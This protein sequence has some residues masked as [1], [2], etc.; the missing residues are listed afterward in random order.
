MSDTSHDAHDHDADEHGEHGD[1][2]HEEHHSHLK[3][4]LIAAGI[5]TLITVVEVVSL[6][7][8]GLS[9][10]MKAFLIIG[11]AVGKFI[12][13]VAFFMHLKDDRNIF[14]ILFVAPLIMAVL[15]IVVV[16]IMSMPH[17]APFG[18]KYVELAI[19]KAGQ[20][21]WTE[22]ELMAAYKTQEAEGFSKGKALY[23]A[24]CVACHGNKGQGMTGPNLTDDCWIHGGNLTQVVST[25][26]NGVLAKGMPAWKPVVGEQGVID[27]AVYV[28]SIKG[29]AKDVKGAKPCQGEPAK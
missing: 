9:E 19:D 2:H 17:Y 28:R 11:T 12:G 8:P 15:M 25:L 21:V 3:G 27:L 13:V 14:R 4:Y 10:G 1:E 7:I 26:N 18:G 20:K 23:D 24:N 22:E 29:A 6:F 5:L 16:S